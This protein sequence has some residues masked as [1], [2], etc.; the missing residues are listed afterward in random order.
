MDGDIA[1]IAEIVDVAEK[2]GAMTYLDEV[3]AR[4]PLRRARRRRRGAGR[5]RA[6][7]H[8]DRGHARQGLR[9]GRRLRRRLG[10]ALRLHPLLCQ[11]LHL[12]H[13]AAPGRRCRRPRLDP[14]PQGQRH[15]ARTPAP[16]GGA[17]ARPPRRRR[18]PASRQPQPHHPGD[19][20]GPG[21]VPAD[22]R[23][24][25]R[26]LRDLRAADQLSRPSRAAPSGCASRPSPLHT[27][28]DIDH[29]V[30]ALRQLWRQCALARAAA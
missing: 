29:L 28:A 15:G 27:D 11:R 6:S 8:P 26:R 24:P 18:H 10:G 21:Q 14:P 3:H 4:R 19:D 9:R 16:P 7:R 23:H 17:P 20:Q 13:R 5:R 1:P 2:H 22:Q 25:A 12:H 30:A